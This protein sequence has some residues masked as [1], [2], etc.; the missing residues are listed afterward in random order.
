M[1]WLAWIVLGLVAG[2]IGSKIVNKR[3]E[4]LFLDI[5]LRYR[6][7]DRR[8]LSFQP[9]WRR[10][11]NGVQYLQLDRRSNRSDCRPSG[12]SR[13]QTCCL[14]MPGRFI[15]LTNSLRFTQRKG[16]TL[17][18]VSASNFRDIIKVVFNRPMK[19][20]AKHS[21]VLLL[22]LSVPLFLTAGMAFGQHGEEHPSEHGVGHGYVPPHGPPQAAH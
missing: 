11:S 16:E 7:R 5:I 17:P 1:S 2:F 18:F 20:L 19:K 8:G 12:L 14:A 3:G 6:W 4:G 9:V 21:T 15:G 10:R 13:D 22:T